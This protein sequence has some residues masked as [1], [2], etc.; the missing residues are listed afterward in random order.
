MCHP[1]WD[2][3]LVSGAGAAVLGSASGPFREDSMSFKISWPT[4]LSRTE[5][6][7]LRHWLDRAGAKCPGLVE[8][9]RGAIIVRRATAEEA[10]SFAAL[11][12]AVVG[13]PIFGYTLE[14]LYEQAES[15]AAA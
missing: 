7:W 3:I 8:R 1:A 9:C 2:A 14:P 12:M 10:H 11:T 5:Q 4:H 15:R 13:Q 6:R